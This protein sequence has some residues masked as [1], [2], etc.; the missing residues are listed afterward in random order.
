MTLEPLLGLSL[1]GA[2]RG[3]K[4]AATFNGVDP[5]TGETLAPLFHSAT[6]IDVDKAA[7]LAEESRA[8]FAATTGSQRAALLRAIAVNLEQLRSELEKNVPRETGL[9]SARI[10]GELTR[11]QF[12][13]RL[14]ADLIE[15]GSW[16]DARID[17]GDPKRTPLPKPD[18]RSLLQPLG[19]V[20]IFAASNF[21]LAF[22]VAGGD[23]VSALA[24]GCPVVVK[25]HPSHPATS[26]RVGLAIRAA[27]AE[28]GL[29]AGVFSLLFDAGHLIGV[30]LVRHPAIRA[31]G[32]T[33]STTGGRALADLAA[34]R[35]QPIPVYAEMGSSNPVFVLP[36]ALQN[37]T[38]EIATMLHASVMQGVGQ[39]CTCP[40]IAVIPAGAAGDILRDQLRERF[41]QSQSAPML[42]GGIAARY[43][44]SVA[45]G[46][47][48]HGVSVLTCG[49]APAAQGAPALLEIDAKDWLA[50]PSLHEEIFGPAMILVRS[51]DDA[52]QLSF[53]A[54]LHG[55]LTATI[56][57]DIDDQDMST[58][59]LPL[60]ARIAG[61]VLMNGVPTGVEVCHAM[62]HGGPYP[63]TSDGRSTS[64]GTAAITRFVRPVCYQN[65]PQA[66]LPPELRDGNPLGIWRLLDG[67][68]GKV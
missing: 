58:Q 39:F 64:V 28:L 37:R 32:F 27:V 8:P 16:I 57:A 63:A 29:P 12:Q 45:A 65:I 56:F 24:A 68:R 35:M 41:A 6:D 60:L 5:A 67:Q 13:L 43:A 46:S 25:A 55:Q 54:H 31:V 11:T 33:G 2:Q 3:A 52:G 49:S 44:A 15:E 7:K 36:H 53:A 21:P 50:D 42:N 61:R 4:G 48:R 18:V 1:L 51:A 14:F 62:V 22:S 19:P 26:E 66:L 23:T 59:L 30:S 17:H 38:V 47:T 34:T 40:G 10:G 20:A 9:P